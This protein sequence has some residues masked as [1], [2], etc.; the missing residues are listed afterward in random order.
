MPS[1]TAWRLGGDEP[2][3]RAGDRRAGPHMGRWAPDRGM[4]VGL[5]VGPR[6]SALVRHVR[7]YVEVHVGEVR[8]VDE[9]ADVAGLSRRQ[10]VRRFRAETGEAP[11]AYVRR[12]R[13]EQAVRRLEAGDAP[14][15]VAFAL[16]YAD[17]AHLTRSLRARTGQTPGGIRTAGA[18]V[19]R[20]A[21]GM[22]DGPDVQDA[23]PEGE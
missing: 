4:W 17:Q 13:D 15:E 10:F 1:A 14:A 22:P 12:V 3:F 21:E 18:P 7:A 19:E 16:G 23:G 6:P 5:G 2:L 20:A 11:W 8:T 9:L